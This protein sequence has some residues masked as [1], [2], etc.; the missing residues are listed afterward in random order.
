VFPIAIL[1]IPFNL[2]SR[3]YV[4]TAS[5]W[6]ERSPNAMTSSGFFAAHVVY[7]LALGPHPKSPATSKLKS[8][9][10]RT[11]VSSLTVSIAEASFC[12]W[13]YLIKR[14]PLRQQKIKKTR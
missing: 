7:S 8:V 14:A 5:F 1:S 3:Y 12:R 10:F 4:T 6:Y 2:E 11:L 13:S 9:K